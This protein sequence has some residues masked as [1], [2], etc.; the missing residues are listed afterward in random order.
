LQLCAT[1]NT[2]LNFLT[3]DANGLKYI[4]EGGFTDVIPSYSYD[5]TLN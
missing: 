1:E 2:L 4:S 3:P 5:K